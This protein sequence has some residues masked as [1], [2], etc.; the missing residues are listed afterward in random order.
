MPVVDIK[1]IEGVFTDEK[2]REIVERVTEALIE[3]GGE[4]LR[5]AT[6][7]LITE[8]PSGGWAIGGRALTAEDVKA[9][10]STKRPR[11]PRWRARPDGCTFGRVASHTMR[12]RLPP[13]FPFA[14][15]EEASRQ[16]APSLLLLVRRRRAGMDRRRFRPHLYAGA[17]PVVVWRSLA[18]CF[19]GLSDPDTSHQ[20]S[21]SLDGA[22]LWCRLG[23]ACESPCVGLPAPQPRGPAPSIS[24]AIRRGRSRSA[25]VGPSPA[26]PT[27]PK[28]ISL[29]SRSR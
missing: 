21:R 17:T 9:M 14:R 25:P 27:S 15:E 6:H 10:R 24:A 23:P 29:P 20:R 4:P 8:T 28:P 1:V 12:V 2:K 19:I 13:G 18:G 5:T 3:I 16:R 26:Q 22:S 7:T 11:R